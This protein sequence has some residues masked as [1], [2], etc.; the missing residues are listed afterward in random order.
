VLN[1]GIIDTEIESE[2]TP[3]APTERQMEQQNN[4]VRK[5]VRDI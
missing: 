3:K 2:E 1:Y 5:A 4:P